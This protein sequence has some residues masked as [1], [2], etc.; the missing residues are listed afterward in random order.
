MKFEIDLGHL[1]ARVAVNVGDVGLVLDKYAGESKEDSRLIGGGYEDGVHSHWSRHIDTS[2]YRKL[3]T[4]V[5]ALTIKPV[6]G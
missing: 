2:G 1:R 4:A 3:P 6:E 5:A